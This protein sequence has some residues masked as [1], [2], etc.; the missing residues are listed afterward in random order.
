MS[1]KKAVEDNL[2]DRFNKLLIYND[3]AKVKDSD[4][5]S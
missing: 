3:G 4:E 1:M 5:E 2:V